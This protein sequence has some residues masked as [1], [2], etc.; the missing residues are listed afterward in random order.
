MRLN[1]LDLTRYGKFTDCSIDFGVPTP[2]QPDL[3]IVYGPNEAGKSTMLAAFLDLLFG[4]ETRTRFNF[5]HPNPTMRIGGSLQLGGT[6]RELIRVKRAQGSLLDA[7]E[8]PVAEA[9]LA[10]ELGGM[11]RDTYRAR[12]SLDDDT[13]EAG[14]E[15][16]L[17]S[18]GD[19]G[20][21]L[22]SASAGLADLSNTL[23]ALRAEADGFYRFH[24]HNTEL[25]TYKASLASLREQREQIDTVAARYAALVDE[26]DQRLHQYEEALAARAAIQ[27]RIDEIQ[28]HISAL[29]RLAALHTARAQLEPLAN[30]P[31]AP[32]GWAAALSDLRD[33]AITLA[34]RD[35]AIAR[36]IEQLTTAFDA[37]VIDAAA[38]AVA[39]RFD[40]LGDLHARHVTAAKDIPVRELEVR[41]A[42]QQ[43]S[44]ILGRIGHTTQTDPHRLVLD[45]ATVGALQDLIA[46][47]SGIETAAEAAAHELSEARDRLQEATA[48]LR[49]AGATSTDADSARLAALGAAVAALRDSDHTARRRLA[50]RARAEQHDLLADRL[51]ALRP[52]QGDVD[53]LAALT[54]PGAADM[55]RWRGELTTARNQHEQRSQEHERAT[56][57]HARLIAERDAIEQVAG[58]VSDQAAAEIRAQ[59]EAAWAAH[60]RTLDSASADAFETMLRHDDLIVNARLRHEA[61]VSRLHQTGQALARAEADANHAQTEFAKAA[62]RLQQAEAAIADAAAPFLPG[63]TLDQLAAWMDRRD[64]ALEAR[65]RLK[66]TERDLRAAVDDAEMLRHRLLTALQAANVA[67]DP[68]AP[69]EVQRGLA[70]AAIDSEAALEKLRHDVQA[71][72][73]ELQARERRDAAAAERD[74]AWHA[75]WQAACAASW[76]G[77]DGDTPILATVRETLTAVAELGPALA[78]QS[79]LLDRI[80]NMRADQ[81][82]FAA[83]VAVIAQALDFPADA[84]T[85]LE[86]EQTIARRIQ[87]ARKALDERTRLTQH[88]EAARQRQ[89]QLAEAREINARR[90]REM[91]D[92]FAVDSLTEVAAKLSDLERKAEFGRQVADATR[93]I[94]DALRATSIEAAELQL[95]SADRTGFETELAGLKA[96]FADLDQ[97][98]RELFLLHSKAAD[99]VE[100]VGGDDAVAKLEEQRRTLLLEIEDRAARYLRLRAGIV[101]AEHALRSYRQQHRSAMMEGASKAFRTISCDAYSGLASQPNRD[102]EDLIAVAADGS[103][104]IAS[105]L[106]KGTRFQLYLALRVA[107]YRE[108]ARMRP[109][110]PFIADDIMETFDDDRAQ[111]AL[112]LLAQIGEVGQAIYLT[113]HRHLCDIALRVC[114][115]VRVH[116][117]SASASSSAATP[118]LRASA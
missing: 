32:P 83:E 29:P 97:R 80:E 48:R 95:Q 102:S 99:Q 16:I 92:H 104:K 14:G 10:G 9:I 103:S 105:A 78:R 110:V 1:R 2:G 106:S 20:Q 93:D 39:E 34:T 73:R 23:T 7:N 68:T 118:G 87:A 4:I 76:L 74:R 18:K 27:A 33:Q 52:W 37:I 91:Q 109:Q 28:R 90:S 19:L 11:D 3:H 21:L 63:A 22:F 55:Q 17:A 64:K 53:A 108:F 26:R 51:Q 111:Q 115:G 72:Q 67:H 89:R 47:R 85:P 65:D 86:L 98:T 69:M 60:R 46:K 54:V 42:A 38:L 116:D 101:A 84:T 100:A 41:E 56:R 35:E 44:L 6:P 82:A 88:L 114:P 12:F 62:L 58:V 50:E 15:S 81:A 5:L 45:A 43:I 107:G 96:K 25:G 75:A 117:L 13:L 79:S 31:A 57:D 61:D 30:L 71:R 59:R 8:R 36:E 24:A 112:R 70:Q 94:L 40:R 77:E 66:Q 49:A 113:H